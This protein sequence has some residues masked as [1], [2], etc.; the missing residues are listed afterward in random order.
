MEL[1]YLHKTCPAY[2]NASHM[3]TKQ[4]VF[5]LSVFYRQHAYTHTHNTGGA[6]REAAPSPAASDASDAAEL[7]NAPGAPAGATGATDPP[8]AAPSTPSAGSD[9][10]SLLSIV[11]S[12]ARACAV[13]DKAATLSEASIDNLASSKEVS[14][15]F[16][17]LIK[18]LP[19]KYGFESQGSIISVWELE[20]VIEQMMEVNTVGELTE[21]TKTATEGSSNMKKF[22]E[23]LNECA[24]KLKTACA[25]CTRAHLRKQTDTSA[26]VAEENKQINAQKKKA[27]EVIKSLESAVPNIYKFDK[28][29]RV[30]I[31]PMGELQDIDER[32][33][34][35]DVSEVG[36]HKWR[37]DPKLQL[38]FGN[39]GSSYKRT[40]TYKQDGWVLEPVPKDDGRQEVTKLFDS[41]TFVPE[42]ARFDMGKVDGK[43]VKA[44]VATP[45]SWGTSPTLKTSGFLRNSLAQ[46]KLVA[47][48]K[49]RHL[50]VKTS[51]LP[52]DLRTGQSMDEICKKIG[53]CSDDRLRDLTDQGVIAEAV[54]DPWQMLYVPAGSIVFEEVLSGNLVFGVRRAMVVRTAAAHAQYNCC[55]EMFKQMGKNMGKMDVVIGL[56][57][58]P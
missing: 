18:K 26:A 28:Y 42:A 45:W 21:L 3:H 40:A 23:V 54:V 11:I 7:G 22:I 48:G 39:F 43:A 24:K 19:L 1:S 52:G 6:E 12:A 38:M 34:F 25:N 16:R 44:V 47:S 8:P 15:R 4:C 14:K 56:L 41:C 37:T 17:H 55:M 36:G 5:V 50:I 9:P 53:Q 51:K 29:K 35:D 2:I 20:I 49:V 32:F 46:I 57:K 27:A 33:L 31:G 13:F 58:P 30:S 10:P